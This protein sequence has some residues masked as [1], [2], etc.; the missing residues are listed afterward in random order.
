MFCLGLFKINTVQVTV[1][2]LGLSLAYHLSSQ[3]GVH[4]IILY[5]VFV[6]SWC[7]YVCLQLMQHASPSSSGG[8]AQKARV[9]TWA[10]TLSRPRI[11]TVCLV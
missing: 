2:M 3:S 9:V 5:V 6:L 1:I 7:M 8:V 11:E 4:N 10:S